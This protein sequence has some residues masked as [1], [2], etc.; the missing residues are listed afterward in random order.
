[1]RSAA[2]LRV[3]GSLALALAALP[4]SGSA[5]KEPPLGFPPQAGSADRIA[6]AAI[7]SGVELPA[8]DFDAV[9]SWSGHIRDCLATALPGRDVMTE[10]QLRAA[11]GEAA[12][13]SL[14]QRF[15]D[16]QTLGRADLDLL[17]A[18][19]GSGV[20]FLV[21]GR[22]VDHQIEGRKENEEQW[23]SK[24]A[25]TTLATRRFVAVVF[26]VCDLTPR[27]WVLREWVGGTAEKES[28]YPRDEEPY[29]RRKTPPDTSSFLGRLQSGWEPDYP[30][31]PGFERPMGEICSKL[32]RTI[33]R[34]DRAARK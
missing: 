17:A 20:R 6:V 26:R 32:A 29:R 8:A 12:Y 21:F 18:R 31:A 13:D 14:V 22:V 34:M 4:S 7:T 19:L 27:A 9:R 25:V 5:A 24:E 23:P 30:T 15:H 33:A 2:L 16:S 1:M 3:T 28:T 11:V 10:E